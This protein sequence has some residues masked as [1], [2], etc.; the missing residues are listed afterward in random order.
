M[1]EFRGGSHLLG[2]F[3]GAL[4]GRLDKG[5]LP[6][7]PLAAGYLGLGAAGASVVGIEANERRNYYGESRYNSYYGRG[8]EG[9]MGTY[10]GFGMFYGSMALLGKD[11]V[12]RV[13]NTASFFTKDIFRIHP[14]IGKAASGTVNAFSS[15]VRSIGRGI[16]SGASKLKA[17]YTRYMDKRFFNSLPPQKLL[18]YP[19]GRPLSG[20]ERRRVKR[21]AIQKRFAQRDRFVEDESAYRTWAPRARKKPVR[22]QAP[23]GPLEETNIRFAG[24][25]GMGYP[26]GLANKGM[27]LIAGLGRLS[28]WHGMITGAGVLSGLPEG[29]PFLEI[30]G[31]TLAVGAMSA[32]GVGGVAVARSAEFSK[33]AGFAA[34]TTVAGGAAYLGYRV[35]SRSNSPAAEGNITSFEHGTSPVSRMNFSTAGLV[36][37]LHNN[38]RV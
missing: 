22:T 11:P 33:L 35:G 29:L 30:L 10:M 17:E 24:G 14:E 36:Q 1:G 2:G 16:S 15:G 32:V 12:S 13:R 7:I 8:A 9:L 5:L 6:R 23:L 19:N 37:A 3:S 28:A 21:E 18:K 26:K 31:G 20:H 27:S 34:S 4:L 25:I 38:R